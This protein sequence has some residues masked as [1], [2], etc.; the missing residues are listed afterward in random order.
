MK[1]LL[2]VLVENNPGVLRKVA[3]LF[4]RR[5][6]NID[7]LVVSETEKSEVS[8][9]TIAVHGDDQVLEQVI[10]QLS[11][12]RIPIGILSYLHQK[13]RLE[14]FS[15]ILFLVFDEIVGTR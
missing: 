10:K 9:M 12:L 2:T 15:P 5:G 4:S 13:C 14:W 7:S 8:R 3:G 1:H 6:Y 11:K